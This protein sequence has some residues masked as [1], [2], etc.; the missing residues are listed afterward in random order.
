MLSLTS[1]I[2]T[3]LS[4]VPSSNASIRSS[5]AREMT[6]LRFVTL[7]SSIDST[8]TLATQGPTRSIVSNDAA[9]MAVSARSSED[10]M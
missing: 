7:M 9:R 10:A 3:L 2:R 6:C 5:R 4:I 8:R 1:S